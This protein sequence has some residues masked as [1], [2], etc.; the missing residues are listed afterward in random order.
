MQTIYATL[1]YLEK[2]YREQRAPKAKI[3]VAS[4]ILILGR[5]NYLEKIRFIEIIETKLEIGI[6]I[7]QATP[8]IL[9]FD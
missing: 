3:L 1:A 2:P 6:E 4:S 8:K 7:F 9:I 5:N